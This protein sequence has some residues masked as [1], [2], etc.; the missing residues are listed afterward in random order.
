MRTSATEELGTLAENNP[1][2]L[3]LDLVVT[4]SG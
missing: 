1:L 3:V 2:T 4:P